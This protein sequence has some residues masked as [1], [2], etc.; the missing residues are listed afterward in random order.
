MPGCVS[1]SAHGQFLAGGLLLAPLVSARIGL[2]VE[3]VLVRPLY[4][5]GIDYPLLLTF[6]LAY[7]LVEAVRI[8]FGTTAFRSTRRRTVRARSTSASATSRST[9]CSSSA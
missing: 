4:G 7:V 6:G 9:G 5:R 2:V 1:A 3:F 8:L